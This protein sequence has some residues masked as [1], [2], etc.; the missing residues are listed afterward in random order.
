MWPP[1]GRA[2]SSM[3]ATARPTLSARA[4]QARPRV[5]RGPG[6]GRGG[7][8]HR[9]SWTRKPSKRRGWGGIGDHHIRRGN[10]P[11][12]GKELAS[13][14]QQAHVG[15]EAGWGLSR[16]DRQGF[17]RTP[18]Q[19]PCHR[20]GASAGRGLALSIMNVLMKTLRNGNKPS[21]VQTRAGP[22]AVGS[23]SDSSPGFILQLPGE[24][25]AHPMLRRRAQASEGPSKV[26]DVGVPAHTVITTVTCLLTKNM[27]SG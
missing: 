20:S 11:R 9:A 10:G 18:G 6:W 12:E 19:E 16:G 26:R 23:A 4:A 8:P 27:A 15:K 21:S 24:C 14:T 3:S 1:V 22:G 5:P 2:H 13:A 7:Q 25:G 17:R